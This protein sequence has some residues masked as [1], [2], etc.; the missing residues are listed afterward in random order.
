MNPVERLRQLLGRV[1]R[2]RVAGPDAEE[3]AKEIW[4]SPGQRWF[5]ESDVIWHVHTDASMYSGGLR[6]LLMQ[7]LH[8]AAMAGVAG[9]SGYRSDPWGRLQRTANFIAI[10]TYAPIPMAEDVI[11]KIRSV[12][13]RV[14]G[15]TDDGTPYRA[16]DPHLLAWVHNAEIQ[17]F[18]ATFQAFGHR[19]LS[20]AEVDEYVANAALTG[21][22]LGAVNLPR[23]E[24][25]LIAAIDSYR[26]ELRM[27]APAADTVDFLLRTPPVPGV[28]RLG[29]WML[30]AGAITTLP[31]WARD[32]LG[33]P[34]GRWFDIFVGRPFGALS[35]KL[36]RWALRGPTHR[37]T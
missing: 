36:V 30:M 32:L 28:A 4:D 35:T 8:P 31:I 15:K 13:E 20:Q 19:K 10:T 11:A 14:R 24:A 33:L 18:L 21:E 27:S 17:S 9:H 2:G 7:A 1:L 25:E 12:H 26:P 34:R 6:S 3:R 22:M 37:P 16:S 23:T 5:D 29:Y